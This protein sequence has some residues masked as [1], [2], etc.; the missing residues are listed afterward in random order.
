MGT[1]LGLNGAH[2]LAGALSRH[3]GDH[4][5]AFA[6][7]EDKMRPLVDGAQERAPKLPPIMYP[8]KA[9]QIWLL[10]VV[11]AVLSWTQFMFVAFKSGGPPARI[12]EAEDYGFEQL[13]EMTE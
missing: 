8:N 3:P 5:A 12:V 11:V 6:E 10:R 4:A 7:Y 9:W 2:T 1:T 13:P